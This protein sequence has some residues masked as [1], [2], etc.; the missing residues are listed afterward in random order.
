MSPFGV[1]ILTKD[2]ELNLPKALASIA[3]RC[4]VV[5]VDSGSKDRTEEIA[6]EHGAEFVYH[7]FED[8]ARQRNWALEIYFLDAD[9]ELPSA[10]WDEIQRTIQRDDLDGAYVRWDVRILGRQMI[11]GEF[12]NAMM[13]R[14]MRPAIARFRRGINERVED[15]NMRITL[16]EERMIHR[17]AKPLTELF[18]KHIEYARREAL[19]YLDGRQ[20][21]PP[22][23][24]LNLRTKAGRV[25]LLR[26]IYNRMPLFV[27]PF[28]NYARV[29]VLL[30]AWR[31]GVQGVI[32]AGM[33]A[34]WYPML[35]DL[36]IYEELL[37]RDGVLAREYAPRPLGEI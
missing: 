12:K 20:N 35:I 23:A 10:L 24:K 32:H 1:V 9:E 3:G 21:P 27:R 7:R 33:H 36:L 37:R 25:A 22:P 5:I 30:G 11:R 13:M 19:A 31:D 6:R 8:Y 29:M 14:L 15:S 17:D 34:L 26:G 28:A 18:K 2:E 16:L 4:P